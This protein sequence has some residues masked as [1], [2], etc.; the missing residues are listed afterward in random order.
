[1]YIDRVGIRKGETKSRIQDEFQLASHS[2]EPTGHCC[3]KPTQPKLIIIIIAYICVTKG[4][5]LADCV[6]SGL[7]SLR[8]GTYR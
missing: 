5:H 8:L 4:A 2:E 1:M 3:K 6:E 7:L